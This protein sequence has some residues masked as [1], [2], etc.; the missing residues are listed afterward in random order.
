MAM[1]TKERRRAFQPNSIHKNQ[2]PHYFEVIGTLDVSR[3]AI[4]SAWQLTS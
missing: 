2:E 1:D 4:A 3:Q